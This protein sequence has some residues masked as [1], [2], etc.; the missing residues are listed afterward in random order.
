MDVEPGGWEWGRGR[1]LPLHVLC[2]LLQLH[3]TVQCMRARASA[4]PLSGSAPR[5]HGWRLAQVQAY[6][7]AVERTNGYYLYRWGDAAVHTMV[8]R[9]LDHMLKCALHSTCARCCIL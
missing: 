4:R 1:R 7:D 8:G 5:V 2:K 9:A 3:C 6:L